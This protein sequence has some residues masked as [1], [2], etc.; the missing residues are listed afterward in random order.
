MVLALLTSS[1][2]WGQATTSLRGIVSDQSGAVIPNVK[3]TLTNTATGFE[4]TTTTGADGSYEFVQALPG[5]YRLVVEV[6][7][8]RKLQRDNVQ[9]LVNSPATVNVSLEVGRRTDT[10]SVT[11]EAPLLNTTDASLG[12]AFNENQVKQLPFESRNVVDLLSLQPGVAYTGNRPDID[13]NVDTRSGAVNGAH[14]D[15]S[16]VT[17]DGVDVN[18]QGNGYAFTSVL[19]VTLESVQEF[20]VTTTNY[21]A[22]QGR[23]SGAQV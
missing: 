15:Q 9:L 19:P 12:I 1:L 17:L 16:N 5:T 7:G 4:R 22:G 18:D 6:E 10:V 23:A 3:V 20:R 2:A 8:F 14:S 11:A 13:L 21:N